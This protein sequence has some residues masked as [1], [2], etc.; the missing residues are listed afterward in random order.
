MD[1]CYNKSRHKRYVCYDPNTK[2]LKF[3]IDDDRVSAAEVDLTLEENKQYSFVFVQE[4]SVG[5]F[6]V[7]GEGGLSFRVHGVNN[8]I[9][10]IYSDGSA[11]TFDKL[12]YYRRVRRDK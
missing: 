8:K 11:V 7:L 4:G 5:L 6:Y 1:Y 9:V 10:G 12:E 3:I 2:K